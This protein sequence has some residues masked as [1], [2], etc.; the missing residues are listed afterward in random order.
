MQPEVTGPTDDENAW[1]EPAELL[2][3]TRTRIRVLMLLVGRLYVR[4]V[5][6][7]IDVHVL[8]SE[9]RCHW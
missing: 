7:L 5:A 9:E 4:D 6:P 3:V 8:P 1:A 2:P